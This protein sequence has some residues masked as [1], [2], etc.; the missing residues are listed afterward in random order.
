MFFRCDKSDFLCKV[1]DMGSAGEEEIAGGT[2]W[3][4]KEGMAYSDQEVGLT[5]VFR[6]IIHSI[7]RRRRLS[8]WAKTQDKTCGN[9][10]LIASV[11]PI[12]VVGNF[13]SRKGIM[14]DVLMV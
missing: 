5:K 11:F 7:R 8:P 10:P 2:F 3:S 13:T 1:G 9:C 6:P 4:R 12:N 14:K